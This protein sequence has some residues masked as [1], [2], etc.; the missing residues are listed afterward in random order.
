[1]K[2]EVQSQNDFS[3]WP[4]CWDCWRARL[5]LDQPLKAAAGGQQSTV[6]NHPTHGADGRPRHCEIAGAQSPERGSVAAVFS[7]EHLVES[8]TTK[9]RCARK[10]RWCC[11]FA[12]LTRKSSRLSESGSG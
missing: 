12:R 10:S 4:R 6:K 2:G 5:P 7:A 11:A 8:K 1:M 9:A 3:S